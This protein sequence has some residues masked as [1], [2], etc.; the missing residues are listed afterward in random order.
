MG[1][2]CANRNVLNGCAIQDDGKLQSTL[3]INIRVKTFLKAQKEMSLSLEASEEEC[4][5]LSEEAGVRKIRNLR[6]ILDFTPEAAGG[7]IFMK[8]IYSC[9]VDQECVRSLQTVTTCICNNAIV[10]SWVPPEEMEKHVAVGSMNFSNHSFDGDGFYD[11]EIDVLHDNIS[12]LDI[13]REELVLALPMY[14]SHDNSNKHIDMVI[15]TGTDGF[16]NNGTE[17][18]REVLGNLL[19]D[20]E[21][22]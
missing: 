13:I 10:R 1:N 20:L 14:P 17:D 9:E 6:C 16:D 11:D 7:K 19:K 21:A 12:I 18:Y 2:N 4:I 5:A 22:R 3:D 15:D 8:G